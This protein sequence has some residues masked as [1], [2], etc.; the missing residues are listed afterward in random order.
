M[1]KLLLVAFICLASLSLRA[2]SPFTF[3]LEASAGVGVWK[4]PL[5]TVNPTF[6]A[7]YNLFDNLRIGAGAGIRF[8]MPCLQYITD[9]GVFRERSFVREWDLPVFLRLGYGKNKLFANL[10]AGYAFAI[11]SYYGGDWIPGGKKDPS[12]NGFFF[13]PQIGY[14]FSQRHALAL[15]VLLQQSV[16]DDYGKFSG[17]EGES[18]YVGSNVT[19]QK[20]FTPAITLRYCLFL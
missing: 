12:Y 13:G 11:L 14:S 16:V 15:G 17:G 7:Q 5:F 8:A 20:I 3:S 18:Y 19:R 6:V 1:K 4:G 9:N 10:D 2:Q